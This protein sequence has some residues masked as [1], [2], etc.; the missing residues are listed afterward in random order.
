M[1]DGFCKAGASRTDDAA[2]KRLPGGTGAADCAAGYE[3]CYWVGRISC[4]NPMV[5]TERSTGVLGGRYA[6][7]SVKF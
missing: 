7:P 3:C 2:K 5:L 1:T 4:E 6:G